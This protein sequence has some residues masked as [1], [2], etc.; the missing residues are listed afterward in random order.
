M[1]RIL[2]ADGVMAWSSDFNSETVAA[3][4]VLFTAKRLYLS[5]PVAVSYAEGRHL[6]SIFRR[7]CRVDAPGYAA[8][9]LEHTL[10]LHGEPQLHVSGDPTMKLAAFVGFAENTKLPRLAGLITR[11]ANVLRELA[12]K[13]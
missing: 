1:I 5:Q 12:D 2:N 9:G 8:V 13:A 4:V 3:G 7:D 6:W 11:S 10:M